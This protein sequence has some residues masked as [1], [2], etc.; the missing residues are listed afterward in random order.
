MASRQ[1]RGKTR[2]QPLLDFSFGDGDA[3]AH[4]ALGKVRGVRLTGPYNA[5]LA[6][7]DRAARV[8]IE[9]NDAI[10][11]SLSAT[12][13]PSSMSA[14]EFT[15]D[16]PG[17]TRFALSGQDGRLFADTQLNGELHMTETFGNI[18]AGLLTALGTPKK[19][20]RRATPVTRELVQEAL[21]R[22]PWDEQSVVE[23]EDGWELRPRIE[24]EPTPVQMSM[25][26]ASLRFFRV[27][28][29]S[30]PGSEQNATGAVADQALR[31]NSRLRHARLAVCD[32]QLVAEARLHGGLIDPAWLATTAFA[33]AV[34]SRHVQTTLRILAAQP[35]V[36]ELYTVMFCS[37]GEQSASEDARG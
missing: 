36:A 5:L 11:V 19:S 24:G 1:A 14:L 3:H 9:A 37:S 29:R 34:A 17:N 31:F 6:V 35:E 18:H 7:G 13:P 21:E 2:E 33:V 32:G 12:R 4:R 26:P 15:H 27:V 28:L 30:L 16:L 8:Q 22:M 25:E 23:Q 20:R 10:R